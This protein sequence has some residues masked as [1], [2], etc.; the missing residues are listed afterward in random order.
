[1]DHCEEVGSQLVVAGGDAAEVFELAE[2]ALDRVALFVERAVEGALF[3]AIGSG[4][5]DG[6]GAGLL[7]RVVEVLGV[8]GGVGDDR[9]GSEAFDQFGGPQDLALLARAGDEPGRL[10]RRIRRGVD[11]GAQAAARAPQ[12]LGIRPPFFLRAPA[13]CW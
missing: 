11:L 5:D 12:P 7:D 8:V 10:A 1:M 13:A 6:S 3:G 4:L 9:S 2:E